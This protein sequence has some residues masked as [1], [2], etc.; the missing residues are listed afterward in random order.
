MKNTYNLLKQGTVAFM[1]I[2]AIDGYRRAVIRD[3]KMRESDRLLQDTL[4]NMNLL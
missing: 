3:N 2:I 1:S 4:K